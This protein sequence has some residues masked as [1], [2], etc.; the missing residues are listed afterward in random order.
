MRLLLYYDKLYLSMQYK[1]REQ[2]MS[3]ER[4]TDHIISVANNSG[5]ITN[6]QLHKVAY[7]CLG[8]YISTYGIDDLVQRIYDEKFE[9][10]PYGPVIRTQYF[11]NRRFG[12]YTIKRTGT[13]YNEYSVFDEL[14]A[15]YINK[16]ISSLVEKSHMHSTWFENRD[17]IL[18][19][20]KVTY[21]LKDLQND[22]NGK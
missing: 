9:A 11:N 8:D 5:G 2:I 10:W 3:M 18:R 20:K 7:F 15:K 17:S 21:S 19:H 4:F 1:W 14:I 13:Y 12:R 22:F 16:P 6:L